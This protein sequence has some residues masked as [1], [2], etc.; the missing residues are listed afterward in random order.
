MAF[1]SKKHTTARTHKPHPRHAKPR[2]KETYAG[3]IQSDELPSYSSSQTSA[4]RSDTLFHGDTPNHTDTRFKNDHL[5]KD[6]PIQ[7]STF[8]TFSNTPIKP[9]DVMGVRT[10]T[11]E[12][13]DSGALSDL[14]GDKAHAAKR[15]YRATSVSRRS[16]ILGGI[17][18]IVAAIGWSVWT[19]RSIAIHVN[20]TPLSLPSN[21]STQD[22]MKAAGIEPSYGNLVA[23]DKS[24]LQEGKGEPFSLKVNDK[25]LTHDEIASYHVQA[26]DYLS[27]GTGA[28]I[29]E[30]Y[31]TQIEETQPKLALEGEKY[32]AVLYVAQWGKPGKLEKRTGK[33]SGIT[34]DGNVVQEV[35]NCIIRRHNVKPD[36]GQK[37]VSVTFDDGPSTFTEKYLDILK[38]YGATTTFFNIGQNV[39]ALKELPKKVLDAGHHVASHSYTHPQLSKLTP[40]DLVSQLTRTKDSIQ[41]ATNVKTTMLRPPYGDFNMTTWLNSK[42]HISSEIL[43][44]QDTLDW[45]QPGVDNIVAGALKSIVPGSIVLMHDGGGKRDQDV[46]A[47]PKIFDELSRQGYKMVSIQELLASDSSIPK[48]IAD[49]TAT[50]PEDCVWPSE[51]A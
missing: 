7:T 51:L 12:E 22:I 10:R 6:D 46:E 14:F 9:I 15:A 42:G 29:M 16:A 20:D 41:N 44:N 5:V 1:N 39:D 27:F 45:K 13:A 8:G 40:D 50:M 49:G 18:A 32:G 19:R 48:D 37:L 26:G 4:D 38:N 34:A 24:I 17:A 23:V 35:Q 11:K 25:Q 33:V 43:W 21:S 47:L 36:N 28:D 2:D 31:T 30:D 3:T